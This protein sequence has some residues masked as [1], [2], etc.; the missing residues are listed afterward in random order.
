M[1]T[2]QSLWIG[3]DVSSQSLDVGF[4]PRGRFL[5][6]QNTP[7]GI[8]RVVQELERAS[9]AGIVCE[10][11]GSY[12]EALA[13]AL[14]EADLPLT[15]VNPAWIKAFRGTTGKLAKTDRADAFLLADYGTY[16]QPAPSRV[17]PQIERDLKALVSARE[18]LVSSRVA[19]RNRLRTATVQAVRASLERC[20]ATMTTEIRVLENEIEQLFAADPELLE[21][22]QVVQSMPG[23]GPVIS[24]TLIA[25]LPD[26]GSLNR[27]EIASLGGL[28]PIAHDSGKQS[29]KRFVHRGRAR[30]RRAMYIAAQTSRYNPALSSRKRRLIAK[31]KPAKVATTAL[32]RWMVTMLNVMLRDGLMW[33]Q[34]DQ[35]HRIVEVGTT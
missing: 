32:A 4:G 29:G 12:H 15:I 35:A 28:A 22:R 27:R 30:I 5:R 18:D 8:R 11:T 26:L 31:G 25:F 20:I 19:Q 17:V 16:Y 9:V 2:H 6:L 33:N 1:H 7:E 10:A 34:L 24:A 21:R 23:V 14:W 3:I 13:G